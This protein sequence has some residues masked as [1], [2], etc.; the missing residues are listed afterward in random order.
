MTVNKLYS[1]LDKKIPRE[2]SC[3]W[4]N[5]GAMCIPNGDR[6]V[7]KVLVALDVTE[8]AVERAIECGC[9]LIVSHHPLIFKGLKGI[10]ES[11]NISRKAIKLIGAEIS[12][13]SFHTRLDALDGGVNDKLCEVLGIEDAI[14]FGNAGEEIGRIGTLHGF[15]TAEEF[16]KLVKSTLGCGAVFL[17]DAG[18]KPHRVAVLGGS[19][20]DDVMAAVCA[21][22]DTYVSGEIKHSYMVEAPENNINII[23][24]GHFFTEQPVCEVLRDMIKKIDGDIECEIFWSD[25]VKTVC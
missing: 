4:D 14:P 13:F 1:E 11:N 21:G 8:A 20:S 23:A 22:A 2:L 15:E 18:R 12:V 5:D 25:A 9:D 24:A 16:A 19:G 10:T 6:E 3:S 7:K 17:S